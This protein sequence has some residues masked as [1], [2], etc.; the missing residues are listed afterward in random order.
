MNHRPPKW[1][2]QFLRWY[3]R[4][5]L[6]ED[7]QG[8]LYELFDRT[9]EKG[10]PG[11]ASLQFSWLV[12]R[13]F[14]LSALGIKIK[15]SFID[16]TQN[17]FKIA[18]RVL[19]RDKFNTAINL[20]GL[21]IGISCFLL[22]GLY[23]KQEL[24]Y[25]QFHSKKDRIYRVW[26]REDYG[27][28]RI[29]FNSQTPLRFEGLFE[30]NFPEIEQAI[31]YTEQNYLVGRGEGRITEKVSI[32]S[33]E[34]FDVFDFT[35][36]DGDLSN[37]LPSKESL[38]ISQAYA[39]KYF[40]ETD[41]IGKSLAVQ[42]GD[43]VRD[44]TVTALFQ[45][46]PRESSI[47]FDIG[48]STINYRDIFGERALTAWFSVAPETYLLVKESSDIASV[49]AKIQDVVLSL[50]GDV[51]YGDDPMQRDQYNIGFQELTAIHLD[52]SIPLGYAPV[53][54]P[55][56]VFILGTIGILVLIIACIN[57]TTLSAGQSL[58][59]AKE[60]GM[61][62]VLGA[63]RG[64]LIYQYLSES[65][66]LALI[67]ML[68]GTVLTIL[69][70]PTFN[71]LTGTEIF[72]QFE[73]WHIGVYLAIGMI[74]GL[75]AGSYPAFVISGFQMITILRGGN[76]ST[77]KQTARKGLVVLQ[78][79]VTVFLIS[80]TLVMRQ[81]V[82]YLQNKDLGFDYEA[83]VA[84]QLNADP[85]AQRLSE[86]ISTGIDNGNL[87]KARLEQ[88]PEIS[89]IAMGSHVFG[90]SG[91]ANVA[92][93]D[94]QDIFRRFRLLVADANYLDAFGIKIKEGRGFEEGNGLDLRQSVI[95]NETAVRYFGFENPVG[96]RLPGDE[97]GEH[98]IIGVTEDFHFNS[99]HS[100]VEPLI[101]VQNIIPI[102][103]G[104]SDGDFVDSVVPKLVFTYSG[105]NLSE[106]TDILK[107]EW[108]AVFP[109][110]SWNYQFLD[111]RIKSQ[112]ESEARM[113]RLI[114]VATVLSIVIA[115]LGLL[116]L[117][118]L[119]VNSKVKE[120]G[121]RKV[122]GASPLTIFKLLAR[123]FSVQLL[124][125]IALSVPLTIWL[126]N[127]WLENFAYRVDIGFWLFLISGLVTILIAGLV[128][129]Y[130]AM[131]AARVNPIESLRAE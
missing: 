53:S 34:F 99:L 114:G 19:W 74:I 121:I 31:Q 57:Y 33:P 87:L 83:V 124:I 39:R 35:L 108:E 36:L 103:Q 110:E 26:L 61:R 101:I 51:G 48:I 75:F 45:D 37:P 93:N 30:E 98:Q 69:L 94:D 107:R 105:S 95:L 14:R 6:L 113:N 59:R 5:E 56:Y 129:S 112:Y 80:T 78:F 13:S 73:W 91:W 106:A 66:L 104:L 64:T 77:G 131:R 55:Q 84:A 17:N 122:M 3:C 123:G 11:V 2:D 49:D 21:T 24:S 40:G 81:Q 16:M 32:L 89:K 10:R 18:L 88:Y 100:E 125:S 50:M 102:A 41:P 126:M 60:V 109:N 85:S 27:E 79:L 92:Y 20:L 118:L 119:V 71:A 117:T 111:D 65:L 120:I 58:K 52:P 25:D 62:K 42:I 7:L 43:D 127:K 130:H 38:I 86:L 68:I 67:A 70:I 44:F 15:N 29:F 12:L 96:S 8:D 76:Q 72:F 47:Q 23:V 63:L 46:I 97:F 82:T 116:G 115:S 1:A 128:V 28:G 4:P 90:T 9:V 22:L 54:N